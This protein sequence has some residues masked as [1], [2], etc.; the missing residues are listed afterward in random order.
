MYKRQD[1]DTAIRWITINAAKALGIEDQTGSIEPGKMADLVVW[2]GN[3]FSVYT[4]AEKVFIDGAL[5]YDREAEVY[6]VT[7]FE[8]GQRRV[9][10]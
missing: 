2:S 5:R 6:P 4:R 7:D 9:E 8:L 10:P 1:E 3:P